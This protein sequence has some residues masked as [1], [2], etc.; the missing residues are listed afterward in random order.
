M[1]QKE[2]SEVEDDDEEETP[3]YVT[4]EE[5]QA[6]NEAQL[7]RI[8][9][10]LS[11]QRTQNTQESKTEA[12]DEDEDPD[13]T[14]EVKALRKQVQDMDKK[15]KEFMA[16]AMH[17]E[18]DRLLDQ[19]KITDPAV[20]KKMVDF[21]NNQYASGAM[22]TMGAAVELAH[23][24]IIGKEGN[25]TTQAAPVPVPQTTRT[26]RKGKALTPEEQAQLELEEADAA[27]W[28]RHKIDQ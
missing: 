24:V 27:V 10:L 19:M 1:S 16:Q 12:E 23:Q 17:S 22:P 7:Q 3:K 26:K 11:G 20:R 15:Q 5:L 8:Q 18:R 9:E 21:A 6:A 25:Q 28:A 13:A 4:A 14:P 2:H